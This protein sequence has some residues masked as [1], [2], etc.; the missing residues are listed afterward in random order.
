MALEYTTKR[1]IA[2]A[3]KGEHPGAESSLLKLRG[4]EVR[5]YVTELTFEAVGHYAFPN[6]PFDVD[7]GRNEPP[8]GP[9]YALHMANQYFNERKISIYSGSNEIQKNIMTKFVLEL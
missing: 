2:A 3:A 1:Y 4:S 7:A 9:D 5:Q 8:I 6:A